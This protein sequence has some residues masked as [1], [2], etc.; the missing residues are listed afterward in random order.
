MNQYLYK[1]MNFSKTFLAGLLAFVAGSIAV[2]ILWIVLLVS[3][4]GSARPA[5]EVPQGAVLTIDLSE[6]LFDAPL[7][8]PW[9]ASMSRR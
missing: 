3:I 9:L 2:T 8:D 7:A 5:V 1:T 4:A 6:D